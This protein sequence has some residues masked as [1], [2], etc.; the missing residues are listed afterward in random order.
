[1]EQHRGSGAE[2]FQFAKD[3]G[4]CAENPVSRIT[5]P[6]VEETPVEIYTVDEAAILLFTATQF[7]RKLVPYIAIGLFAGLRSSELETLEWD[8]IQLAKRVIEVKASKSKTSRHRRVTISDNLFAWLE[9]HDQ[10]NG[11]LV[12]RG[13]R[14]RLQKLAKHLDSEHKWPRNGLRHS[15]ASYHLAFYEDA[16]KTAL[17]MG[18]ETTKMLFQHYRELVS[19]EEAARFWN[20]MPQKENKW[21]LVFPQAKPAKSS[22]KLFVKIQELAE[23]AKAM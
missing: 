1:M 10:M 3:E 19:K 22:Q 17:Q 18:H 14:D 11:P 8:E 2:A 4:Y 13:W 7:D 20:L 9:P 12:L 21:M 6:R 15:F 23:V 5:K 16:A